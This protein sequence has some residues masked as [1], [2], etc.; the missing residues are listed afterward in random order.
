LYSP[1]LA[2]LHLKRRYAQHLT[3]HCEQRVISLNSRAILDTFHEL[4]AHIQAAPNVP[5]E[6]LNGLQ[7]FVHLLP[8]I[9]ASLQLYRQTTVLTLLAN[10]YFLKAYPDYIKRVGERGIQL[11][12]RDNELT[13]ERVAQV[14]SSTVLNPT[15]YLQL[16]FNCFASDM[17]NVE[18]RTLEANLAA[19]NHVLQAR[20]LT[21]EAEPVYALIN[22]VYVKSLGISYNPIGGSQT[23]QLQFFELIST[24][25]RW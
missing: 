9:T 23:R 16:W 17:A 8:T 5:P 22:D 14:L 13:L 2:I 12:I 4:Q 11:G 20:L 10:V 1:Y 3:E 6:L 7:Q 21:E 18:K 24:G 15:E 19:L 25:P